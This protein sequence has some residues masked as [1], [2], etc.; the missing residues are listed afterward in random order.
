M[1][2]DESDMIEDDRGTIQINKKNMQKIVHHSSDKYIYIYI[3]IDRLES[4]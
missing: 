2:L 3:Y 1:S 4:E